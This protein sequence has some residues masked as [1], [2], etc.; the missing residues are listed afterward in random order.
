MRHLVRVSAGSFWIYV[1]DEVIY[2][3]STKLQS[4]KGWPGWE[5]PFP[6]WWAWLF[7]SLPGPLCRTT[8]LTSWCGS[9]ISPGWVIQERAGKRS[10]CL[11]W[12]SPRSD[13]LSFPLCSVHNKQIAKSSP[14]S[15]GGELGPTFS[16]RGLKHVLTEVNTAS[17]RTYHLITP[18]WWTWTRTILYK[19]HLFA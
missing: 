19:G 14:H 9:R 11:L 8:W 6:G 15:R 2:R 17:E 3:M 18:R 5:D 7:A 1:F 16:R 12:H 13:T 10:Q 4:S